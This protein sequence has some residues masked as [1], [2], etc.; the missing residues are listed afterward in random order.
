MAVL[1]R[2]V[3]TPFVRYEIRGGRCAAELSHGVIAANHRSM[4]DVVAGLV[5]LHRFGRYPRLL[6]ERK[7]VERG[8]VGW[9][10]RGI[11]A[12][13]VD[14]DGAGGDALATA[15]E[16]L[17]GG[18]TVLVMP[19][20]RL[21]WDP[22]DPLSTGPSHTGVSRLVVHGGHPVVPAALAGTERVL[23]ARARVPR[24][25]PFR[26]KVVACVVADDPLYLTHDDHRANTDLVMAAIRDLLAEAQPL[27]R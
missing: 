21:H 22:D 26:R 19:E 24:F 6:I 16:A 13:P 11:G 12:I 27:V 15:R 3:T 2:V 10:A 8:L 9:C 20:G 5:C 23:P 1:C 18:I 4:F 25:V 17:A 14:R 7:Y